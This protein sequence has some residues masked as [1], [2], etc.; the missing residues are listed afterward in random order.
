MKLSTKILAVAFVVAMALT[1]TT[2][3][4]AAINTNLTVGSTGADVV[5]LQTTLV[6][7]GYLTMPAGVSMGYFGAATK[8]AVIKYQVA[9]GITPAAGFVGSITR[10]ALNGAPAAGAL[11]P[12]GK[13]L[14]SNCS[15]APGA[16]AGALCPNGMTLA[17]NC[18]SAPGASNGSLNGGAGSATVTKTATD[19]ESSVD[20]GSSNVKVY[21]FKVEADG[22]DIA[23]TSVKVSFL[24][25]GASASSLRLSRYVNTVSVWDGSTKIGS[26]DVADFTK[27]GNAYSKT[28]SLSN[29]VVRDGSGNKKTFYVTVDAVENIDTTD[30]NANWTL[31]VSN[32]RFTDSTGAILTENPN[33]QTATFKF[34]SL[35]LSGNAKVV[36]SKGSGSPLAQRVEVSDTAS[37]KDVLMLEFKVKASDSAVSFD[38]IQVTPT[39]STSTPG[40]IGELQL[41]N[42]S[43]VLATIDGSTLTSGQAAT[44][45]LDDTFNIAANTTAVF[46][47]YATVN[48]STNFGSSDAATASVSYTDSTD[49]FAPED[50]NGDAI[51]PTGS[52]AGETQSFAIAGP[53]VRLVSSS[54]VAPNVTDHIDG[55]L[56]MTF[57]VAALGDSDITLSQDQFGTGK[58][59]G[60]ASQSAG[61]KV[62][63]FNVTGATTTDAVL[64]STDLT[65]DGSNDFTISAGDTANFTLTVKLASAGGVT[66]LVRGTITNVANTAIANL[67][68]TP[69]Y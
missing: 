49:A 67:V 41:R 56:K 21:G 20:E 64:D 53:Q 66:G 54:Y 28:I 62:V 17:S 1:I 29:A 19:V 50:S 65:K 60:Q 68:E 12:N 59:S 27:S 22:S 47:V 32:I 44:F 18:M 69:A 4:S 55:T 16:A 42:G 9:N 6:S 63:V 25:D 33:S 26:A 46:R 45:N 10:G 30:F 3:A 48:D 11:C 7:G 2:V 58:T 5:A 13:T 43:T 36:V 40:V 31:T 15:T 35:A 52:A 51:N 39:T 34:T 61:A 24:A 23:V 37:T 14:A 8:A 38:S 57:Q